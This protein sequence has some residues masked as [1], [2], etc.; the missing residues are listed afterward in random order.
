MTTLLFVYGTLKEGFP[1]HSLNKGVRV[2]GAFRTRMP[3]PLYVV[4]LAN[5]ERAPWLVDHPGDGHRVSGQVFQV[6]D[7]MLLAMDAFEEVGLPTGYVRTEIELE[8]MDTEGIAIRA[9]AYLK[10]EHQLTACLASEG[11]FAEYT[12]ALAMGYRL[13]AA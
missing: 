3:F 2:P 8:S 1:N 4:R 6:D 5:E 7:A 11:P 9:H 13:S 10:P 12:H